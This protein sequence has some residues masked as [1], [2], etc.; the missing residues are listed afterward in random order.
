MSDKYYYKCA[1]H[2]DTEIIHCTKNSN[3]FQDFDKP[4]EY[5]NTVSFINSKKNMD[6]KVSSNKSHMA[7]GLICALAYIATCETGEDRFLRNEFKNKTIMV[8]D[9]EGLNVIGK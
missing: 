6:R 8:M 4:I 3:D 7:P 9:K 1:E 5:K 2:I